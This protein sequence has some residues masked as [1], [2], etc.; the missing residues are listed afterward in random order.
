MNLEIQD[1]T[2]GYAE[3]T[4]ARNITLSLHPGEWLSLIGANGSGKS[5]KFKTQ[6]NDCYGAARN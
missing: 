1:L 4:I 6:I 3:I 5:T 2:G